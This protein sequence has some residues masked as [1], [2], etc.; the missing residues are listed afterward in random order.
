MT[1]GSPSSPMRGPRTGAAVLVIGMVLVIAVAVLVGLATRQSA[2]PAVNYHDTSAL[3]AHLVETG[4]A[5]AKKQGTDRTIT[6]AECVAA[7]PPDG[8]ICTITLST[9]EQFQVNVTVSA[10]GTSYTT[11]IRTQ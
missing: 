10:D 1:A 9:K 7:T 11:A 5:A 3:S 4:N 2:G 6:K 8:Y